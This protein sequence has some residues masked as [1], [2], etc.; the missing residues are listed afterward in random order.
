M[1][2]NKNNGNRESAASLTREEAIGLG[3]KAI[4]NAKSKQQFSEQLELRD[5]GPEPELIASL[6]GFD[7]IKFQMEFGEGKYEE[8]IAPH[9]R[10]DGSGNAWF[11]YWRIDRSAHYKNRYSFSSSISRIHNEITGNLY[12]AGPS[13]IEQLIEELHRLTGLDFSTALV[14]RLDIAWTFGLDR[15]SGF[16]D[17]LFRERNCYQVIQADN[18]SYLKSK[19]GS[20]VLAIYDKKTEML[21]KGLTKVI[22]K[23]E[24]ELMRIE[25]RLFGHLRRTLNLPKDAPVTLAMLTHPEIF[26]IAIK[27]FRKEILRLLRLADYARPDKTPTREN[28]IFET[29]ATRMSEI[30]PNISS[31]LLD[32]IIENHEIQKRLGTRVKAELIRRSFRRRGRELYKLVNEHCK[33]RAERQLPDL[34]N[35]ELLRQLLINLGHDPAAVVPIG[36]S[37]ETVP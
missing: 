22:V 24:H 5:Y 7:T 29:L 18:G 30:N 13:D 23:D 15:P 11:Y 28:T 1:F 35:S 10:T 4:A 34:I 14:S 3:H 36:L 33:A 17:V 26:A 20:K 25:L 19:S 12:S 27:F 6:I 16:Y 31:A 9:I 32:E 21:G 37:S 8:R 2:T